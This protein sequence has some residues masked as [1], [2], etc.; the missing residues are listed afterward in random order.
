L[1][2]SARGR[3]QGALTHTLMILRI[4]VVWYR[5]SPFLIAF[6]RDRRRWILAGPPRFLSDDAHRARARKL[7]RTIAELGPSFIKLAQVF[8]I[9]ADIIPHIYIEELANLHD[10]VP[11]FPTAEV[12]K[13]IQAEL[14]QPLDSVFES[15]EEEPLAAAS[16][17]QV[18]RARYKGEDV[19]VKVL[20]PG[21][22]ELVA[23]DVRVVQNLVF[24]LEQFIDHHILRSTRTIIEEFSRVIAEEMDFVHE[25]ENV[26]RFTELYRNSEFV[27]IPKIYREVITTRIL[28]MQFF[29]GFRVDEVHEIVRHN[30]DTRRMIE[31]LIEFYGGQLLIHGFFHADPH[32]GNILVQPDAR[33]VLL[34]YGMVVEITPEFRQELVHAIASA[35]RRDMDGLID[36]VYNLDMLEPDVSPS[37]VREAA[38]AI[39]S[40]H[41]DKRLTQRQIQ[42]ISYQILNTFYRFPLR[43]PSNLVY[44]LRT[45]ALIEGLG[46]SYDPQFNSLTTAIPIYKKILGGS[47]GA[48]VWPTVKDRLT[49]E[50]TALYALLKDME[51]VFARAGRE[52]LRIRLHPADMDGLEKFISHLFRRVVMTISGV[53]LA[54]V[55]A[56]LYLRIGSVLLLA[57]GLLFSFW[58]ITLVFLLPNPQRY[59]FRVRRA[60]KA[61]RMV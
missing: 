4:F 5:L 11:P 33:I 10:R 45:G 24:V 8:A 37:M 61:G 29:E 55:T 25:A 15:F 26:E 7:T 46:I 44:I 3:R 42:E 20:R 22:E 57:F 53:G 14:K 56:I 21:V 60:R 30:I 23:T 40:I 36:A 28:V 52:Q 54:V 18:H 16:L 39:M 6:L 47:I 13:R 17:G 58:L 49:K 27:I 2:L 9:R 12:R 41:L 51:D 48:A 43:L 59:P 34:D 19:I 31:N 35:V 1:T 38:Q 32:P 50:G